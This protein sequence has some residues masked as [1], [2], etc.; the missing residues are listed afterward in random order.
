M[1]KPVTSS[2][3]MIEDNE[4]ADSPHKGTRKEVLSDD[5]EAPVRTPLRD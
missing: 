4:L 3:K 1:I 5:E 2:R